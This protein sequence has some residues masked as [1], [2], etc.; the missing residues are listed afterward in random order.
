MITILGINIRVIFTDF[1]VFTR[2]KEIIKVII[3][4][5]FRKKML[6][7]FKKSNLPVFQKLTIHE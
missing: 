7:W 2:M 4:M 3:H 6:F 5:L 1:I